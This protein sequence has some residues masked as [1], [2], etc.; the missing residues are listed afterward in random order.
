MVTKNFFSNDGIYD[1]IFG[2]SLNSHSGFRFR[3]PHHRTHQRSTDKAIKSNEIKDLV[4]FFLSV[5]SEHQRLFPIGLHIDAR[6]AAAWAVEREA[7]LRRSE[8]RY[9]PQRGIAAASLDSG[10]RFLAIMS[11]S[12][13]D[14]PS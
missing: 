11:S 5:H 9:E 14:R 2:Y 1:G 12:F 10:R 7:L 8:A 13:P 3:L 4:A 6:E